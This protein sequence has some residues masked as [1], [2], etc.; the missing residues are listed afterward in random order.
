MPL[1]ASYAFPYG[2]VIASLGRRKYWS[3]H[4]YGATAFTTVAL[5][6]AGLLDISASGWSFASVCRPHSEAREG[7]AWIRPLPQ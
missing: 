7:V 4:P 6:A 3:D 1:R 5:A 2:V